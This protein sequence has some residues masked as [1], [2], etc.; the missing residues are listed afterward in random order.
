[1]R[2]FP[3]HELLS[4]ET[5]SVLSLRAI[6]AI[7]LWRRQHARQNVE[8]N[9]SFLSLRNNITLGFS[10]LTFYWIWTLAIKSSVV[11]ILISSED[12][13]EM[14][15]GCLQKK[16][17]TNTKVQVISITGEAFKWWLQ[18]TI[19]FNVNFEKLAKN[20]NQSR[21]NQSWCAILSCDRLFSKWFIRRKT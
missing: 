10:T 16:T 6:P 18:W 17:K 2:S 3:N 4:C 11:Y 13:I 7:V 15:G 12:V 19:R 9:V 14:C 20:N 21:V 1:M 5:A 8:I